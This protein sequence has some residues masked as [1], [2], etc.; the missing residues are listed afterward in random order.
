MRARL[1]DKSVPWR[2]QPGISVLKEISWAKDLMVIATNRNDV[3][4]VLVVVLYVLFFFLGLLSSL[5]AD[6]R[7]GKKVPAEE[8]EVEQPRD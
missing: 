4:G 6:N 8:N 2:K 1:Y 7:N 5:L 3:I